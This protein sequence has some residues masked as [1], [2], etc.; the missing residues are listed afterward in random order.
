VLELRD[1]NL[2]TNKARVSKPSV[3]REVTILFFC[4]RGEDNEGKV[5]WKEK[6][7]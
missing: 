3:A 4:G 1:R 7:A 5:K 6:R 2:R